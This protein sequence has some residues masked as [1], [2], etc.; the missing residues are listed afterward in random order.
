MQQVALDHTIEITVISQAETESLME[1]KV[2]G[3]SPVFEG[4]FPGHPILPGVIMVEAVRSSLQRLFGREFHLK[5]ALSIKFLAVL[6]P[7]EN[8]T[9]HLS[10]K[11]T[12][13]E[14]GL[15]VEANLYSGDKVFFK[16]K[17]V[18]SQV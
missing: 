17:G 13:V 3:N 14:D 7:A 10:I 16:M 18:Y 4:H 11:H 15:K 6:N 2:L 12:E 9:V 8:E 1:V 5:T